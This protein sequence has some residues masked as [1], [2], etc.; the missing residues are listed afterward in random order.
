MTEFEALVTL[1][2][3]GQVGTIRLKK[4]LDYFDKPQNIFL[5]SK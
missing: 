1:N 4:L 2:M 3:A 5:A